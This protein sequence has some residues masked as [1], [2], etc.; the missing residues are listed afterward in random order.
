MRAAGTLVDDV[1]DVALSAGLTKAQINAIINIPQGQRPDPSTYL[2]QEYI[3]QHLAMFQH[4]VSKIS[5]QMPHGTVGPPQG[6]YV[7]PASVAD[8]VIRL[9][10]GNPRTLEKLLGLDDN[11]LGSSPVR[12]DVTT[13]YGLRMPT[14]NEPGANHAWLPGGYTPHGISEAVVDQL[15]PGQ[16][17]AAPINPSK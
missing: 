17:T 4:G 3:D 5:P 6:T 15:Q 13:P 11:W 2:S 14:E 10:N 1:D 9:S 16:F 8:E 7:M 12:I